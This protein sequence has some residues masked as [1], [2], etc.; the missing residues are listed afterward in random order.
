MGADGLVIVRGDITL[1]E[2]D[3]IVNA[4]NSSLLQGGSVDGTRAYPTA[5][6]TSSTRSS[7]IA[8]S[9]R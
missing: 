5:R 1:E 8:M 3:A 2:V 6:A 9:T 4:A 7:S